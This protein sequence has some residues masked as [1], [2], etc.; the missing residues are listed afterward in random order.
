VPFFGSSYF[1]LAS[2]AATFVGIGESAATDAKVAIPVP[3]SGGISGLR[4]RTGATPGNNNQYTFTLYVNGSATAATCVV[5]NT[6]Q[7]CSYT[8]ASVA[9]AAGD[10]VS[11]QAIPASNP[12][13][14]SVTWSYYIAQ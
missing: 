4:V 6:A 9:V 14:T 13:G 8:G 7:A 12:T 2:N 5:A 3:V 11:L 1:N 10:R